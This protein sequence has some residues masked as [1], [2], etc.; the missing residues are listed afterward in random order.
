M[1]TRRVTY[2]LY[3]SASQEKTLYDWRR[4][5][6]YLYNSAL[7]DRRDSYQREGV[8]VTY[9][10]QQNRLPA[11]KETWAEYKKLGSHA[12]QATLKRVDLAYQRFFAGKGGYPKFKSIR[13]YSGWSYPCKAGWKALTDQ[14]YFILISGG[15][16]PLK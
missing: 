7:A 3:P 10:D 14:G 11:F 15:Q 8:S 9:F 16:N 1:V 6:A 2:R 5:H 4:L 13:H 12:L